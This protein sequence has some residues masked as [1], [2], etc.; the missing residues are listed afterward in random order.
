MGLEGAVV[1]IQGG[2]GRSWG[3]YRE[4]GDCCGYRVIRELR[5][6]YRVIWGYSGLWRSTQGDMGI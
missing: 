4:I 5:G 3:G 2:C 6:G 1:G